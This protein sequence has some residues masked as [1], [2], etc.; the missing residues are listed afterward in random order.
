MNFVEWKTNSGMYSSLTKINVHHFG[1]EQIDKDVGHVT[2]TDSQNITDH[3]VSGDAETK[4]ST[5][6]ETKFGF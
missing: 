1:S 2:I 5:K 4:T 6:L 3:R